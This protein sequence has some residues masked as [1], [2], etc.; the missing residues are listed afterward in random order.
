[1]IFIAIL[2]VST[3]VMGVLAD[4]MPSQVHIALAGVD[5][6]GNPNGMAI[7]WQTANDTKTTVVKYGTTSGKYDFSAEG[8]SAAYYEVCFR[9]NNLNST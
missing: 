2:A 7:G 1:M 9:L 6:D 3:A 8:S 5:K 4:N